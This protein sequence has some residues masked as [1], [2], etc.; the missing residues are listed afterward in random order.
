MSAAGVPFA[1]ARRTP[2]RCDDEDD[3][4]FRLDD[5]ETVAVVHLTWS[6]KAEPA[7]WPSTRTYLS[8]ADWQRAQ[9]AEER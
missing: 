2:S 9:A 3:V 1:A 7:P 6:G 4:L 8:F 5:G